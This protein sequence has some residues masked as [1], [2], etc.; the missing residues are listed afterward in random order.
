MYLGIVGHEFGHTVD[1]ERLSHRKHP[2]VGDCNRS[3]RTDDRPFDLE[4]VLHDRNAEQRHSEY[5]SSES[6]DGPNSGP[7]QVGR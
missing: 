2:V 6:L 1:G 5:G 7:G 3:V 4:A